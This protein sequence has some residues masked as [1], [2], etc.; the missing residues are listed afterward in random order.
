MADKKVTVY[1]GNN[2]AGI[3]NFR[4][5]CPK[6]IVRLLVKDLLDFERLSSAKAG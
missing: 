3:E 4:L 2:I 5:C 6:N 1:S